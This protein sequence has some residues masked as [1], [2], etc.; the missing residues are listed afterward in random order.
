M[1]IRRRALPALAATLAVARPSA[2][3][4]G[5]PARPVR[6]I[7]PVSPG[8]IADILGRA[9]AERLAAMWRQP[10]LVENRPG[11]AGTAHAAQ[12]AADGHTLFLNGNG[13]SVLAAVN[14][15]LSFDPI[16][17]FAAIGQLASLPTLLVVPGEGPARD[18]TTLLASLRAAPGRFNYGSA[19]IGSATH[20]AGELLK[21]V[22]RLD[23]THVPYRGLPEMH[24]SVVR[25]DTA[26]AFTFLSGA[27]ELVRAGRLR[28]LAVTGTQRQASLPETPTFAEAGL[29][30]FDYDAW[31]ALMAPAATPAALIDEINA[32]TRAALSDADL[33]AR[34]AAQGL[35]LRPG[36]PAAFAATLR[37]DAERYRPLMV[38]A[39]AG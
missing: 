28:A 34:F 17:D 19:G 1:P 29:P 2:A 25:G 39:A 12:S 18:L 10:V 14:A 35:E 21:S 31:F 5:F 7:V 27:G 16:N 23:L 24:T 32:A 37:R 22:A 15:N 6:I 30:A 11:I 3:Q 38:R 4:P 26:L 8:S 20:L 13:Q 36:S 9:L 33:V